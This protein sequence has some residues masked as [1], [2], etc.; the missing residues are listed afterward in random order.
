[1]KVWRA[2]NGYSPKAKQKRFLRQRQSASPTKKSKS[3]SVK[4]L[5]SKK[6]HSPK[7]KR[8]RKKNNPKRRQTMANVFIKGVGGG[9][10]KLA[11]LTNPAGASDVFNGYEGYDDTGTLIQGTFTPSNPTLAAPTISISGGVVTITDSANNG[12]FAEGY[13]VYVD[14]SLFATVQT[15]WT[16]DVSNFLTE[17]GTYSIRCT[18]YGTYFNDSA[19]S[20]EV[21]YT[22]SASAPIY[23][24]SGL[25]DNTS[26]LT[27]TDDAIGKTWTMSNNEISSDFDDVFP[28]NQMIRQTIGDNVFVYVPSIW[29]RI[30]YNSNNY[31]TDV[32][33]SETQ[34]TA[35]EGQVV[36]QSAAFYYGAYKAYSATSSDKI[37]SQSGKAPRRQRTR[38]QFRDQA[39]AN[40]TGYQIVDLLHINIIRM[41]WL[42]EFAT[43]NSQSVLVGAGGATTTGATDSLTMPSGQ[44]GNQMR[45]HYI[46]DLYG[47]CTE[48]FDGLAG[49]YVS[50]DASTY[51]DDMS[52]TGIASGLLAVLSNYNAVLKTM[53]IVNTNKPLLFVPGTAQQ[54]GGYTNY[55]CDQICTYSTAYYSVYYF[56][57]KI[58]GSTEYGLFY[59]NGSQTASTTFDSNTSTRLLYIPTT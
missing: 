34:M 19:V 40:G 37:M 23:G 1:M 28:Y 30:G 17:A 25:A 6:K 16:Y 52:Q 39:K 31:I 21:T 27:R 5:R 32:A 15:P 55:Y 4:S 59:L 8:A 20:N 13:K 38:A 2:T 10:V 29:W 57:Q 44:V 22:V 3:A 54:N 47:N 7:R 11:T 45:Y 24:V 43:K 58:S 50:D 56:G 33:V 53:K 42:I 26:T 41:L 51:S 14:G 12:N 48:I 9:G 18:V 35:G 46:E 49:Q 36:Y